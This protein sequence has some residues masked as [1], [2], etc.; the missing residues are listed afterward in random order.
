LNGLL[1]SAFILYI[2]P[3]V[4]FIAA[5][6][7]FSEAGMSPL[8]TGLLSACILVLAFLGIRVYDKRVGQKKILPVI[9]RIVTE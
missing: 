9:T 1:K 3:V 2:V 7:I 4:V 8:A 6:L 5:Y